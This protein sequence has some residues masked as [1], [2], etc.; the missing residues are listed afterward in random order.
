MRKNTVSSICT[1]TLFLLIGC[2]S[3]NQPLSLKNK[4]SFAIESR[5]IPVKSEQ[6]VSLIYPDWLLKKGPHSTEI[7]RNLE[8]YLP[9]IEI[10][11]GNIA[12]R[13]L[14]KNISTTLGE[15]ILSSPFFK[16]QITLDDICKEKNVNGIIV[17]HKGEIVYQEYP[18][19]EASDKH[20]LGS[21]SKS[22]VGTIIANLVDR[23]K[24]N[25][26]DSIGKHL[27][28]FKG[29][30]LGKVSIE[31]LLRM[32]SGTNCREHEKNR[33]SFTNPEH[34]FY[35]LLE[36][37][38]LFPEPKSGFKETL[39]ELLVNERTYIEAGKIYDYTSANTLILST[40]AERVTSK[41]Y[42]QLVSEII[43]TKIGAEEDARITLSNTGIAGSYGTM[44][45]TLKDLT[46]YG[47]AFMDSPISKIASKRYLEEIRKGDKE[48]FR[49]KDGTGQKLW[50]KLFKEQQPS[51]QSYHWDVVFEDGDFCKFGLGGQ[52][53]YI[54]PEREL[55]IT[56]FSANK[57]ENIDNNIMMKL[58]RSLALLNEFTKGK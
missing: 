28:E 54:S 43:W 47:S 51:H 57:D 32:A 53:L 16:K 19:M 21:V 46:R 6:K 12:T 30:P 10:K 5:K 14:P 1:L 56:F 9:S 3:Q 7:F 8:N 50:L 27:M 26:Q 18:D 24:L 22:F 23:G 15:E 44:M 35:K 58:V 36:H 40:I 42:H 55:V 31:N 45:M 49:S 33:V 4:V 37:T 52:G 38:A 20:F 41:P 2:K 17:L 11:K 48:L 29:S 13:I 25:E 39:M 34:C